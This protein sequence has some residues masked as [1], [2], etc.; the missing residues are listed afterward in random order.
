M[1]IY[2]KVF[3]STEED[4]PGD[5]WL[6]FYNYSKSGY[7]NWFLKDGEYGRPSIEDCSQA[8]KKHMPEFHPLWEH[9]IQ[10][11]SADETMAKMLSLYCP[12]TTKR[13][14]A[15]A[16]WT[17]D[18]PILVRN[19]DYAIELLEGRIQKTNWFGTKVIAS[20]DSLWGALDGMNEH[21]LALSLA[22]G[23][24]DDIG[25][26]FGVS[27][28]LRYILEFCK[29]TQDAIAVLKR[30]PINM[31]YNITILDSLFH[32]KT[33]EISPTYG[34]KEQS[35][36]FAVNKQGGF[37]LSSYSLF[38][39]S[40]EKEK[41][42]FDKLSDPLVN[43]ETFVDTFSYAPLFSRNYKK[44]FGT[45]YTVIYNPFLR[46]MEY[47]WPNHLRLYQSFEYFLEQES[48]VLY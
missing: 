33:L 45:L 12:A 20:T 23:G 40:L 3:F 29:N 32:F 39:N 25:K 21:G 11:S 16:V 24:N 6:L 15:Q 44:S 18:N 26:G 4:Y 13:G 1:S 48:W 34:V 7:R 43:I 9:L 19:Y 22:Y 17:R 47:R 35:K 37:D 31:S 10:I 14:C 5:K 2:S 46:A 27:L 28:V 42:I 41:A 8:L 36:P 38:S 30:V